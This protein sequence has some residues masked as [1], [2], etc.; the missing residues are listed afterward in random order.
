MVAFLGRR[1]QQELPRLSGSG[2][3]GLAVVERLGGDFA[4]VVDP[5]QASHQPPLRFAQRGAFRQLPGRTRGL[6]GCK[7]RPQGV[8][9]G[10]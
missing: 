4:R 9:S 10:L 3:Q 1:A 5:H 8:V 7:Q 2:H 6:E